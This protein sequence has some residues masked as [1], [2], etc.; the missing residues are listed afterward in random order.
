MWSSPPL[1]RRVAPHVVAGFVVLHVAAACLDVIP[2]LSEGLDRR[3]WREPRVRQELDVWAERLGLERNGLEERLADVVK[4]A[5]SVRTA[6][7]KPVEPYLQ[8]S[9]M[10]QSWTM[11]MAG[12][13]ERDRFQIRGRSCPVSDESCSWIPLYTQGETTTGNWREVLEH[14]RV[15]SQVFR[16]GWARKNASYRAG[17]RSL[18]RRMFAEHV[19]FTTVECRF[20][21]STAPGP[22]QRSPLPA[23]SWGRA[24]VV[25][26]GTLGDVPAQVGR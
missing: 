25:E 20:E 17:C 13:P 4:T 1:L 9:G 8:L 2:G 23:P 16:W 11:F 10:K 6:L 21:R 24:M 14:P 3:N 12:T 22:R 18:A 26:R 19:E 5:Q 15:R 7:R